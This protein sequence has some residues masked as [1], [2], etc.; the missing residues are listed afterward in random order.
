MNGGQR[1]GSSIA[2]NIAS[3]AGR[4]WTVY[5]RSS[6]LAPWEYGTEISTL[7]N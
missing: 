5:V 3:I 2:S 6:S 7:S 4:Q 1:S